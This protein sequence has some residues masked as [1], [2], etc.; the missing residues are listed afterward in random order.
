M[1]R[2]RLRTATAGYGLSQPAELNIDI[3]PDEV[4][5]DHAA[6]RET[7]QADLPYWRS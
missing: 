3:E 4:E 5:Q 2:R 7:L 6:Q 1:D